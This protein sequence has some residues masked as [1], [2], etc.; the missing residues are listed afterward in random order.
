MYFDNFLKALREE[1]VRQRTNILS[2]G[3]DFYDTEKAMQDAALMKELEDKV[4]KYVKFSDDSQVCHK[5]CD[6]I[7]CICN[8]NRK[9]FYYKI[10]FSL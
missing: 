7:E 6:V 3:G 2:N 1:L 4:I 5:L 9:Y 10:M 8:F